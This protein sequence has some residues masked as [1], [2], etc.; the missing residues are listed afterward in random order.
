LAE[1]AGAHVDIVDSQIH[2]G[3][4]RIAETLAAMDA[5]GIRGALIDEYW[6]GHNPGDPG[7]HVPVNAF[8]PVQPT[9]ELAALLHPQRFSYLV[10]LDR[11]DRELACVIRMARDAPHARAL[12]VTPGMTAAESAA[13]AADAYDEVCT[14]ACDAGLPLFVFAPG[15]VQ[16]I[17]QYARR[18]SAL[19]II[20]DHCGLLSNL[21]R[22]AIGITQ[23]MSHSMQLTAYEEVL[24]LADFP[25]VALKWAHAPA[26]FEVPGWPGEALWPI[27]RRTLDRFGRDRIMWASDATMNQTGESWAQLLFA[28][29]SN[30][31]LSAPERDALLGGTARAWLRWP[32]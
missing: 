32:P 13:F 5:L 21:M 17:M 11:Q 26:M 3:P 25:N 15:N 22:N 29:M 27:L 8:R 2:M 18:Y 16:G 28:M 9:A 14:R 24:A 4:G 23:T 19:R 31:D 1:N 20:V 7:Y 30:T 12:R 6:T 10:R